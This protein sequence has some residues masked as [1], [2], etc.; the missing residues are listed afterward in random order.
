ML[1]SKRCDLTAFFLKKLLVNVSYPA[2]ETNQEIKAGFTAELTAGGSTG[3]PRRTG[4]WNGREPSGQRA[5]GWKEARRTGPQECRE[6][7]A[8]TQTPGVTFKVKTAAIRECA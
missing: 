6:P 2:K 1:I 8:G 3:Q 5:P 7:G 4:P